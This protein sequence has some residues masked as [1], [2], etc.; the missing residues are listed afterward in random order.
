MMTEHPC[1]ECG[2]P[3][4]NEVLCRDCD[5]ARLI[6]GAKCRHCGR[7]IWNDNASLMGWK[8]RDHAP[9]CP[10]KCPWCDSLGCFACAPA[11]RTAGER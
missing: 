6:E 11:R 10:L 3:T 4:L 8:A 2:E 7:H 9:G 5:I 1:A